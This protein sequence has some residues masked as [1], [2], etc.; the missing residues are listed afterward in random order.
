MLIRP[1][2]RSGSGASP[3]ARSRCRCSRTRCRALVMS[4]V[5]CHGHRR[6]NPCH[7]FH[8][9][10]PAN[11]C[12]LRTTLQPSASQAFRRCAGST[13]LADQSRLMLMERRR[14]TSRTSTT[15]YGSDC[16]GHG[17][18]ECEV[19]SGRPAGISTGG[20][21]RVASRTR[22]AGRPGTG[23]STSPVTDCRDGSSSCGETRASRSLAASKAPAIGLRGVRL[24]LWSGDLIRAD[25]L[26]DCE[27]RRPVF[28]PRNGSLAPCDRKRS[29][30]GRNDS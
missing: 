25:R 26:R 11:P 10:Q 16:G 1:A 2:P 22:R 6:H 13:T 18:L 21:P 17:D 19:D 8:P 23:L 14:S 29:T 12:S 28:A 15:T 4:H 5:T 7:A 24:R 3:C 9:G 20:F 30:R 27:R